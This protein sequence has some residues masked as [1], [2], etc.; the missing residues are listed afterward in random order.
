MSH[1]TFFSQKIREK[2]LKLLIFKIENQFHE[3]VK[4]NGTKIVIKYY[5][6]YFKK[7][8][9]SVSDWQQTIRTKLKIML[10]LKIK[11]KNK[12]KNEDDNNK[13]NCEVTRFFVVNCGPIDTVERGI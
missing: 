9:L 2:W 1:I 10:Y 5:Y 6:Y 8:C 12:T 4:N 13:P 3:S 11:L 7:N